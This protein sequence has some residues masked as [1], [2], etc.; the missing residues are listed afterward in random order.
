MAKFQHAVIRRGYPPQDQLHPLVYLFDEYY[1]EASF[2]LYRHDQDYSKWD[3]VNRLAT[4]CQSFWRRSVASVFLWATCFWVEVIPSSK[5]DSDEL[6][7]ESES[8]S[9]SSSEPS[10]GTVRVFR[11]CGRS[12]FSCISGSG[13][14]S[15]HRHLAFPCPFFPFDGILMSLLNYSFWSHFG[16]SKFRRWDG[17]Y[18]LPQIRPS[19]WS[20]PFIHC[21]NE[22][23]FP[24]TLTNCGT[25]LVFSSGDCNC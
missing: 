22:H 18:G 23:A 9:E 24:Q 17:I 19:S 11:R 6:S 5:S 1:P 13:F 20:C 12:R 8:P 10:D 2:S 7:S 4:R 3:F 14:N 15:T 16:S 25:E 21:R